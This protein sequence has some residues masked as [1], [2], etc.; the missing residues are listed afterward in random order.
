MNFGIKL[1]LSIILFIVF[2]I[3]LTVLAVAWGFI[4][5]WPDYVH[6]N[7]GL[8]LVWATHTLNTIAGP[9]DKWSVNIPF[10]LIDL[11][12]WQGLMAI[13]ITIV[14]RIFHRKA[15]KG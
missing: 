9:V 3:T 11:V 7:F 1:V 8:P 13:I 10:L 4:V 6:V 5:L 14:L 2:W 15:K 12:F